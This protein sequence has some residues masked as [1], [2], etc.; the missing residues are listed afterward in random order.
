[1]S[2]KWC[3]AAS[4]LAVVA[5]TGCANNAYLQAKQRTAP[6]GELDQQA[7]AAQR[8]LEVEKRKQAELQGRQKT[9]DTEISQNAKR[10]S[11]LQGDLIKQDTQLAAA[12]KKRKITKAQHD[13]LKRQVEA[14]RGD[15]QRVELENQG[16]AL[17]KN[18]AGD[19]EKQAQLGKLEERKR[20][21]EKSLS[22]MTAR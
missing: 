7:A 16:A 15:T 3:M 12:L 5:L 2:K 22:A 20:A 8:G 14:L 17:S 18:A 11:A 19:A 1:M 10:I 6:G 9:V 4:M 21:L 13:Q